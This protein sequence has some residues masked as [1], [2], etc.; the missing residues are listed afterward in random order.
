MGEDKGELSF[1]GYRVSVWDDGQILEKDSGDGSTVM[2]VYLMP[3]N[4]TLKRIKMVNFVFYVFYHN[5]VKEGGEFLGL[6]N[7]ISLEAWLDLGVQAIL[8]GLWPIHSH[9]LVLF[10][11]WF[12]SQV[13]S[14]HRAIEMV[15][16]VSRF[17]SLTF[18]ILEN[19]P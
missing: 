11:V 2:W 6:S 8:L 5:F 19:L 15:T 18:R 14:F 3:L 17:M 7:W 16:R 4:C 10:F 1:N 12:Q 9:I 13:D